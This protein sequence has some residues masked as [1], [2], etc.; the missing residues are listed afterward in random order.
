VYLLIKSNFR[1]ELIQN[2]G[3][4]GFANF[5][6]Y[7]D[8]KNQLFGSLDEYWTESQRLSVAM[9]LRKGDIVSLEARIMPKDSGKLLHKEICD[10]DDRADMALEG[11]TNTFYYTI[12]FPKIPFARKE[13][14]NRIIRCPRNFESRKKAKKFARAIAVYLRKYLWEDGKQRVYGI[15]ACSKEIGCRPEVFATEFRYIRECSRELVRKKICGTEAKDGFQELG[16]TYHVGEDFLD[17]IDGLR[18]ID[19]AVQFFEMRR[20]DR[21]GHAIAL[22]IDAH[23]YYHSKHDEIYLSKQDY[24]DN[25]VWVLF[26]SLELGVTMEVDHR[27]RMENK[28]RSLLTYI[29]FE[30]RYE[31][32]S[33][34]MYYRSWRLRGDHPDLYKSGVYRADSS[35]MRATNC[36]KNKMCQCSSELDEYRENARISQLYYR[37]HYDE[38]VKDRGLEVEDMQIEEQDICLV[39]RLQRAMQRRISKLALAIECNPTSNLRISMMK[40]YDQHPIL[41]FNDEYIGDDCDNPHL[42]VSINT[43][44]IGVFDTSLENEYAVMFDAICRMR[45]KQNN[46]D[47][48]KVYQYL[49]YLRQNGIAMAFKKVSAIGTEADH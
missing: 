7:Q 27:A 21:I 3:L 44:D 34:D 39:E 20:G 40:S 41:K 6:D 35:G 8:R 33:L 30:G 49:D 45:H 4:V 37:Y 16:I 25:L 38:K 11:V 22:G 19:E 24:L 23:E 29:Y 2:N 14:A 18:A 13:Y 28:A 43:D 9:A 17:I 32:C 10:L 5:A 47:D 12:H 26:R 15:D 31:E 48:Y 36:Y 42:W 46:Y 1:S